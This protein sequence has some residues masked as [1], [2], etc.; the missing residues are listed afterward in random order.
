MMGKLKPETP[1]FHGK[2]PLV[3]GSDFPQQTNPLS[4]FQPRFRGEFSKPRGP[5]YHG[6]TGTTALGR[7]AGGAVSIVKLLEMEI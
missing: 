5:L 7:R 4:R 3:S 6:T 2:N 1:I